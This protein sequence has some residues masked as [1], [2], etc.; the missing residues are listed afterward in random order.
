MYGAGRPL[1][2]PHER[3]GAIRALLTLAAT[4]AI[5]SFPTTADAKKDWCKSRTCQERVA[6]K[7]CSQ[8][9]VKSCI[10]R[11]ALHHRQSYADLLRVAICESTLNPSASNGQYIGL[12]QFGPDAWS[13]SGYG[14]HDRTSA[15][16]ASLAAAKMWRMGRKSEWECV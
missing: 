1:A 3:R 16:W 8:T 9:R 4:A 14:Q 15:K 6:R 5:L 11:A 13:R 7:A 10:K 12:F 2:L